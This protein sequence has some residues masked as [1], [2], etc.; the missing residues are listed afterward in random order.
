[1]ILAWSK[2]KAYADDKLYVVQPMK[3][4]R[5]QC[6]KRRNCLLSVCQQCFQKYFFPG[7][8]ESR[9]FVVVFNNKFIEFIYLFIYLSI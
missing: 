9:D 1:M 3:F 2:F 6:R 8:V 5:K 7:D 4:G